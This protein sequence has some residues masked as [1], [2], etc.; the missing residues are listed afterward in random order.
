M[1]YFKIVDQLSTIMVYLFP[2]YNLPTY[3]VKSPV[4]GHVIQILNFKILLSDVYA[5]FP[6]QLNFASNKLSEFHYYAGVNN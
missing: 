2:N 1:T 3:R 4:V 6:R 5:I